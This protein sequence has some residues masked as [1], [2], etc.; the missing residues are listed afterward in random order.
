MTKKKSVEDASLSLA[1]QLIA[2][3]LRIKELEATILHYRQDPLYSS[4]FAWARK[5]NETSEAINSFTL[6]ITSEDNTFNRYIALIKIQD[7]QMTIVEKLRKVYLNKSEA[8]LKAME[9][10]DIPLIERRVHNSAKTK[11]AR[12]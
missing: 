10:N 8:D 6:S 12:Q 11:T 4:Y 7:E 5:V 3:Q 9:K 2:A 1:D